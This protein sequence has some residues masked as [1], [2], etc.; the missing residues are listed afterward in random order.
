MIEEWQI[1]GSMHVVIN[2]EQETAWEIVS[3]DRLVAIV[4][5]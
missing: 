5:D 4:F 1:G 2:N 3:G